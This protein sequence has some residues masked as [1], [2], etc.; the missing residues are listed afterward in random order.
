MNEHNTR[1]LGDGFDSTWRHE[2]PPQFH[3]LRPSPRRVIVRPIRDQDASALARAYARLSERSRR[4]RFL[5]VAKQLP[6][7]E[8]RRL[9]SVDHRDHEAL[10]AVDPGSGEIV[11]SARYL[12]IRGAP[13]TAE[14]AAEVI[15]EWQRRG[16]GRALLDA[17]S[18]R[19]RANDVQQFIATVSTENVPVR[20]V[21]E[22]AGATACASGSEVE[23]LLDIDAL[24]QPASACKHPAVPRT[25]TP[26]PVSAIPTSL[27]NG[28]DELS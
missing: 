3:C 20:R 19:A 1:T 11:G 5:S 25:R 17:L 24:G 10:V 26:K 15:D 6:Q 14:L 27:I 12:R 21:L 18:V 2:L 9:T 4:R 23:Y 13:R 8:L 28:P 7:A 22:R 16:V